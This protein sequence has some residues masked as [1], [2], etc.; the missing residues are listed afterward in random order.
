[1]KNIILSVLLGCLPFYGVSCS[2]VTTEEVRPYIRPG[3][4]VFA[5]MFLD[6]SKNKTEDAQK[7]AA[8]SQN[9]MILSEAFTEEMTQEDFMKLVSGE[10]PSEEWFVFANYLFS[11]YKSKLSE[12]SIGK[13]NASGMI[14]K[15]IASGLQDA[16]TI[17]GK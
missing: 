17:S 5:K 6:K 7:I 10:K 11:Y 9:L 2:T 12:V 1:M 4:F 8:A 16:L 14:L 15:E 13:L 3:V